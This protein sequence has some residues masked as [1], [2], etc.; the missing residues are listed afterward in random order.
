MTV[1]A[2]CFLRYAW[3]TACY[4]GWYGLPSYAQQLR[5]AA[6]RASFYLWSVVALQLM[7]FVVMWSL[8]RLRHADL[9]Q[10][11]KYGARLGASVAITIAGSA[12]L[13]WLMSWIHYF[14]IR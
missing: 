12:L 5:A 1:S 9:S 4:S 2:L 11:L 8:I 14:H 3:W 6:A 10:F 13:V 7:T